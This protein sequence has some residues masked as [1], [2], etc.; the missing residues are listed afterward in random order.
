MATA[1]PTFQVLSPEVCRSLLAGHS[2]GRVG[3]SVDALPVVLPVN[4]VLDL[5]LDRVVLWSGPGDKLG[6]ALRDA[7]VCFEIDGMDHLGGVDWSVVVTGVAT[8]LLGTAAAFAATLRLRSWSP[9]AGDR[10]IAI[11]LDLMSGR[12]V[13][14]VGSV[15]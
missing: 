15:A 13:G 14:P 3:L 12:R 2:L 9:A 8:E 6:A 10:P 7:V 1:S 5:V 4:Y 11:G